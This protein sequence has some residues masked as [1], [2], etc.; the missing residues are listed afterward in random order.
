MVIEGQLVLVGGG[1]V[2]HEEGLTGYKHKE[3]NM[4]VGEKWIKKTF[5]IE[6]VN[7]LWQIDSFGSSGT[8]P[9]LFN[10]LTGYPYAVLN[11]I[12]DRVKDTLKVSR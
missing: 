11:R 9:L 10:N 4:R 5:D 12:G 6:P 3:V 1:W 8:T 2:Q 7:V